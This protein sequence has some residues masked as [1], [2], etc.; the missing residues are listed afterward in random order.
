ME[1]L[2]VSMPFTLANANLGWAVLLLAIAFVLLFIE[3]FVPSGGIIMI[4]GLIAMAIGV[5]FLFKVDTSVGLVGATISLISLPIIFAMGMKLLPNTPFFKAIELKAGNAS[6][7]MG[8]HGIA[9]MDHKDEALALVGLKGEALTDLHPIGVCMINGRRRDCLAT[10]GAISK[11]TT[12]EVIS[13]D[14]M[15]VKVREVD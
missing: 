7:K 11:G 12:I 1:T 3:I 8:S 15:Q 5:F 9:G 13:A 14:G 4:C 10:G 6:A 2:A